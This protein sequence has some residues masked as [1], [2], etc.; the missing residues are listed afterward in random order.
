MRACVRACVRRQVAILCFTTFVLMDKDNVLDAQT[1]FVSL[2]YLNIM[3]LPMN[4][5]PYVVMFSA[6]VQ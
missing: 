3:T 4:V 2:S 5:V 6:Q 1:A